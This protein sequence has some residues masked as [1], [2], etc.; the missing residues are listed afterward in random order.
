MSRISLFIILA[1]AGIGFLPQRLTAQEVLFDAQAYHP[2]AGSGTTAPGAIAWNALDT[3]PPAF[4]AFYLVD[5]SSVTSGGITASITGILGTWTGNTAFIVSQRPLENDYFVVASGATATMTISGLVPG[6]EYYLV[7]YHGRAEP[8]QY[9]QL[10][11]AE[12]GQVFGRAD[13]QSAGGSGNVTYS[14]SF[15]DEAGQIT[16]EMTGSGAEGDFAGFSI[17]LRTPPPAT[18]AGYTIVDGSLIDTTPLMGW[19][20]IAS[21]PWLYSYSL[22]KWIYGDESTFG[23]GGAW[24]YVPN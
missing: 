5:S 17:E 2:I 9:R 1:I 4:N 8:G 20:N 14:F 13:N 19:L 10:A 22:N 3:P 12:D 7:Y 23:E 18:W 21:A 6:A 24:L 11:F 16:I 15:A